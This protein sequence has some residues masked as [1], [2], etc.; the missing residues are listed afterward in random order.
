MAKPAWPPGMRASALF[1]RSSNQQ[2][3]SI[4]RHTEIEPDAHVFLRPTQSEAVMLEFGDLLA[5]EPDGVVH[6]WPVLERQL[7]PLDG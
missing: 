5:F 3:F 1:G 7:R 2:F 6:R 4:P